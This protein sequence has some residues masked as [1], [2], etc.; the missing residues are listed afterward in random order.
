MKSLTVMIAVMAM[1]APPGF[2]GES[3]LHKTTFY[4][5]HSSR[6]VTPAKP[7]HT[8]DAVIVNTASYESGISPGALAT[9][10]GNNLTMV[11]GTVLA[12]TNP[13]PTNLAGVEVVVSGI[14]APIYGIA[15]SGGEDQISIQVPYEAPTG[16]G[17]AEIQV[18][19]DGVL[20]AD[21]F[22]DSFTEDPGIFTYN[23]NFAIAEASDYSLI[24]PNNPAIPGEPLVLYV[25]GLGPLTL[26]LVDGY[27]SPTRPPFAQTID[28]FQVILDG[29]NCNVFFSGLAPG[30][31]GLYQINFYV[32]SDAAAGNL[33]IS[34]QSPYANSAIA[35]LPVR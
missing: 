10:F 32:P 31:V 27:G 14:S 12:G 4:R 22:A 1:F 33:Q 2:G 30:F 19:D 23:G 24:G 16:P 9:I 11:S 26:N 13:L 6:R 3:S 28:P 20:V 8:G 5:P 7:R 15:Y 17:A 25:T 34:I 29:E 21:F 35:L 18:F